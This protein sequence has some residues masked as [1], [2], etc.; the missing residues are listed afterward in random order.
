[1]KLYRKYNIILVLVLSLFSCQKEEVAPNNTKKDSITF[2]ISGN[3]GGGQSYSVSTRAAG[4]PLVLV[5]EDG[6]DS[7]VFQLTVTDTVQTKGTSVTTDNLAELCADNLAIMAYYQNVKFIDD[8]LVFENDGSARTSTA[9]YWP[10]A[11]DAKVD[12]WSFH[13]KDIAGSNNITI[14]NDADSPYFSFHYNQENE[15]TGIL[16]DVTDQHDLFMSYTRQGKDEGSVELSFIHALSAIKFAAGKTLSGKIENIQIS[17]IHAK[18]TLTYT[19]NGVTKLEWE[20]DDETSTLNQDFAEVIDENLSGD[21]AQ[22]ITK[23]IEKTTF[24]LI[25]Q[26][27]EGKVLTIKYRKEGETEARTYNVNMPAGKWEPGK[28]YTYNLTLMDGLGIDIDII[29]GAKIK[30]THNKPC[31]IRAMI[32]GN[33]VDEEGNIAAI[34]NPDEI[35]LKIT[36]GNSNYRLNANWE[37]YWFYDAATDIYYYKKPL[38]KSESTAANLFDQ[39]TNPKPNTEGLKLDFTVLVQAVEAET[40]KTSVTAAWGNAIAAQL[41]RLN[42]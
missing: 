5:S 2:S 37:T 22:S 17:N 13:P 11:E 42:N 28:A 30:N 20:L 31:Y 16:A 3:T 34:F 32:L 21:F 9:S 10:T 8:V 36:S 6:T 41:E 25:P 39:F 29:D 1:M 15:N 14:S 19:P 33:W 4:E 27:L 40:A 12:F 24:M 38:L 35:N 7:L 18:G 23:E 26:S